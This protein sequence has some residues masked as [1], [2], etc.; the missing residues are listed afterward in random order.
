MKKI[1]LFAIILLFNF[2]LHA[3]RFKGIIYFNDG[4]VKKGLLKVINDDVLYKKDKKTKRKIY[5]YSQVDSI[6]YYHKGIRKF[7]YIKLNEKDPPILAYIK[8]DDYLK[9]YKIIRYETEKKRQKKTKTS[10][11]KDGSIIN[12]QYEGREYEVKKTTATFFLK[13]KNEKF[14]TYFTSF[15]AENDYGKSFKEVIAEY[16]KDCQ[17][18]VEKVG[19]KKFKKKDYLKIVEYYNQRC[20]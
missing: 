18:I 3:Q 15:R 4:T 2:I 12:E 11:A 8:I 19:R 14:V 20:K 10:I 17:D 13:R 1:I 6:S 9:L 7:E 5:N 16:F